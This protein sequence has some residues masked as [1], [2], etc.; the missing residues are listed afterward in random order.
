MFLRISD[1]I[2]DIL[3][4]TETIKDPDGVWES[5]ILDFSDAFKHLIIYVDERK[6]LGGRTMRGSFVAT[7][8]RFGARAGP[9]LWGRLA[10][11]AMRLHDARQFKAKDRVL[12]LIMAELAFKVAP[13]GQELWT[14]QLW[15]QRNT[16]CDLLSRWPRDT[17]FLQT[18][19]PQCGRHESP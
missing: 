15:T 11:F 7:V 5:M 10:A 8:L 19:S 4:M 3:S 6:Y 18:W 9:L 17:A 12:N 1:F 14:A 16:T 13:M 2:D